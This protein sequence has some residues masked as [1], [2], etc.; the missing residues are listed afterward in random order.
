MLLFM[1]YATAYPIYDALFSEG[2]IKGGYQMQKFNNNLITGLGK[3]E[4]LTALSALPYANV[5]AERIDQEI[6]G[7]RYIGIKNC[8]GRAHKF[9]NPWFLYREGCKVISKEKPTC[10][11]C[12]AIASSPCYVSLL[13]GWQ[14]HIPVVGIITDLPGMLGGNAD[15]NKGAERLRHFDGYI[16]L[17]EQMNAVV[18]PHGKPYMIM[19]G[20]CAA[21]LPEV[22]QGE[23]KKYLMYTGSLWKKDAGIEYLTEGFLKA[24][25]PGYE[26][27]FYGTGE[28]VPWIEEISK[29]HP[30]VKYK[31]CVTNEEIVKRQCEATLLINP[32]PSDEE[33][34]KYSFPSKT[35][36]Y[37]ASG[38]PVLMTR[39]PGVPNEYFEYVFT[40]MKETS[41]G[42]AE[43]LKSVLGQSNEKLA[44]VGKVARKYVE[45]EKNCESQCIRI[46]DFIDTLE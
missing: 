35:I 42:M 28:L 46:R 4:R 5:A 8:I 21:K 45:K 2:K 25:L 23:K 32:R 9:T 3:L 18:N 7:I 43:T 38:T 29:Q 24:D 15:A 22:Y 26:L 17:T 30:Y 10:I 40:V 1:S 36:E 41:E 14:F 11:I 27:H 12:D 13:L 37:M 6:E 39:L 16:L 44:Q 31:G 19:E 20:L 34:C 33:F